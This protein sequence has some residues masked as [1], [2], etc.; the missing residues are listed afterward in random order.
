[1]HD[2]SLGQSIEKPAKIGPDGPRERLLGLNVRWRALVGP[3]PRTLSQHT[4]QKQTQVGLLDGGDQL[5][6][7]ALHLPG[8]A[9]RAILQILLGEASPARLPGAR[10]G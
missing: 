4:F 7:V 10:A 3:Q 2:D 5:A 6:Q 1:M 8:L 9:G